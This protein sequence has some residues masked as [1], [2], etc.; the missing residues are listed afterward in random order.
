MRI[1]WPWQDRNSSFSV[2]KAVT[3]TLMLGPALWLLYSTATGGFGITPIGE[4]TFWSGIWSMAILL[5]AL[6]ITPAFAIFRWSRVII[7]RRMIGVTAL[8]YTL[9]H[10]GIYF[11]LRLWDF[12]VIGNEMA[13]SISLIAATVSTIG[14]VA[15]GATSLDAAIQRMGAKD[16]NRLHNMI[17]VITGL[18]LIHFLIVPEM[19]PEQYIACGMFFWLMVW[20]LLR[21]YRYGSNSRALATLSVAACLFTAALEAGWGWVYYGYEPF[22][23]LRANFSLILG[24]SPAW[25]ML[26]FGL[27]IAF[28]AAGW[29]AVGRRAA[30][31]E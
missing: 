3:F 16:W 31:T 7:V 4:L 13:T 26:I 17:Y 14:L 19:Y 23:T 9:A 12:R 30:V 11:A 21:Q 1:S 22:G 6:A 8:A 20:R 29:Q 15:L 28:A 18:A 24:V 10:I 27:L 2:L 5:L 25:K